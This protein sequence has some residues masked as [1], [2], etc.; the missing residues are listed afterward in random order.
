MRRGVEL[1]AYI[2]ADSSENLSFHC[3]K[4]LAEARSNVT[5]Q[6]GPPGLPFEVVHV[7]VLRW[8]DDDVRSGYA[9]R[10]IRTEA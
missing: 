7:L 4:R 10:H 6:R 1:F 2:C 9:L 8:S 5:H 3:A